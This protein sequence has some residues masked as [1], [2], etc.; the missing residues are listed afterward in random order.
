[1]YFA[2]IM[3]IDWSVY[4]V[5]KLSKKII[6][7]IEL[8]LKD[9]TIHVVAPPGAGKTVLGVEIIKKLDKQTLILVPSLVLK[10]QWLNYLRENFG[11]EHVSQRLSDHKKITITT[12]Q[13]FH[14][15]GNRSKGR[16]MRLLF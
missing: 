15:Q 1:M 9:T 13:E 14:L 16:H 10:N 11:A 5:K 12:Y 4:G 2:C 6:D 8:Y 7:E 3:V